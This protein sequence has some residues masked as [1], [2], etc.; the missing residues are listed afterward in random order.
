LEPGSHFSCGCL[1]SATRTWVVVG[2]A[3]RGRPRSIELRA[4]GAATECR[5]YNDPR[6]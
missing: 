5:P 1:K 2:A 3:L 6:A 4:I